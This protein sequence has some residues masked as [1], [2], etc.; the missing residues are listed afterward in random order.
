MTEVG[1]AFEAKRAPKPPKVG[2]GDIATRAKERAYEVITIPGDR[3]KRAAGGAIAGG[4]LGLLAGL[5]F[6]PIG[7]ITGAV[8]GAAAGG[9]SNY[10]DG[11]PDRTSKVFNH[12]K[13][14]QELRGEAAATAEQTTESLT[15]AIG[16]AFNQY[17]TD[18]D[19]KVQRVVQTRQT[20][21]EQLKIK[22]DGADTLVR[23]IELLRTHHAA[24]MRDQSAIGEIRNVL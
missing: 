10:M 12:G 9:G 18:F 5:P 8:V 6:G 14:L 15:S 3:K 24:A 23:S 1:A 13:Y 2:L 20:A 11:S 4:L 22:K 19:S 16:S 7:A 17:R 21:Y